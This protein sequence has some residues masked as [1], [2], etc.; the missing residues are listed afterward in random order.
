MALQ[1]IN[2]P[3]KTFAAGIDARSAENQIDPG[4]VRDLLN[5]DIVEKRPKKRTGY[6]GYAGNIP[7]RVT[8]MDYIDSTNLVCFTLDSAVSLDSDVNLDSVSS[9]PIIVYG[10]SSSFQPGDGPFTNAGD[11]RKYYD[12]FSIP[13]R[14]Q[15]LA[16]TNTLTIDATEHGIQD[17]SM[18]VGIVESTSLTNRSYQQVLTDRVA[19]D[20]STYDLSIDY[21]SY[22]NKN[23]YTYYADKSP[24]TGTTYTALITH[25]GAPLTQTFS[26]PETTHNLSNFNIIAQLQQDLTTE[27]IQVKPDELTIAPNG[28]VTVTIV[29]D[30]GLSQDYRLILSISPIT[31]V[32]TGNVN[33]NSTGTVVIPEAEKPWAFYGIYLEQTPGG[34]KE[35]VYPDTISYD[36]T[37]RD[38]TLTFTNLANVARNFIV[39]YDYG[40]LRSNQ[41]CV[42]DTDVTVDGSDIR[43]QLT[44]WGLDHEKIYSTEKAAREGWVNHIDSYRRSGEERIVAGLGGNLFTARSYF[45]AAATYG[46]PEIHANVNTRTDVPLTI[47]PAFWE[48]GELPGRTRGYITGDDSGTNWVQVSA[49][50]YDTGNGWT[51]Y[52]LSIPNMQLLDSAGNPTLLSN[53]ISTSG[54]LNDYLTVEGMSYARHNGVFKIRQVQDSPNTIDVWVENELNTEDYDDLGVGGIAGIFTDQIT[55]L[56]TAPYIPGDTLVSDILQ[57]TEPLT[58]ASSQGSTTVLNSVFSRQEIAAGVVFTAQRSSDVIPFRS[59][60]PDAAATVTNLVQG[61][62]LSYQEI[63]RYLRVLY[64]NP[65]SSRTVNITSD[66]EVATVTLQS[67]DT[68]YLTLG[69]K[70]LLTQAADYSGAVTITAIPSLTTFQFETT[71]TDSVSGAILVGKTAQIDESL[72]WKDTQSDSTPFRVEDRWIPLE[73]PDDNFDLTPDTYVRHLDSFNYGV[74]PFLRSTMVVDNLYLTN[75]SDEVYKMDGTNIYRAGLIPWQPGLFVTQETTGATIVTNLRSISYSAIVAGE[76]KLTVTA[77]TQLSL[78]LGT[79]VRLSG[80]SQTYIITNHSDDGSN[81]YI[82]MDR[83]L[84][85]TVSATGTIAEIGT[86]R[87]YY[88]LNAVDANDNIIASA[89]TGFQDHVV[90]LTGNAAIRHKI[91]G[92]PAWDVY[93]YDRLEVQIFRTKLNTQAPFYRITTL[94]MNFNNTTGYVTFRDSFADVDLVDLD[95]V[96]TSLKGAELGT[97]WTGPLRSKYITSIGNR[98]VL[99]NVRDYPELSMQ[100]VSDATLANSTLDG[101]SLLFRRSNIDLLSST[102]NTNR[103]RYEWVNGFTGTPSGITTGVDSFT[104]QGIAEAVQEGD[105]IY[106]TYNTVATTGRD[107]AYSGWWQIASVS[108]AGPYDATINF[109]GTTAPSSVPNRYVLASTPSDVPVLLGTDGNLGMVNGDSFDTFDATRR[110]ALAINSSMR[111]VDITLQGQSSFT[112]WLVARSGNDTPPAGRLVVRQPRADISIMEVVPTFSG[113]SLFINNIRRAT[114][115]QVSASTRVYPSRILVSYENYPEIFDNPTTIID[116]GSDSAIDINSADGQEITGILP[117][118]GEAAFGAAQQSAILVVFKTNSIYLVDINQKLQGLNPVQRIE[119]EGL[120]CTFPYSI[121]V[122]KKGIIFAN[123]SGIYCLRR[124]QSIEYLGRFM[125]RNWTEK[126]QLEATELVQGHHYGVGRVYKLSVPVLSTRQTNGYNENSEVYVYNHTAEQQGIPGA[127]TRYDNH[128]ATGWANL[129][130]DA[131]FGSTKGRVFSVRRTGTVTDFRD[132]SRPIR[133]VLDTRANDFGDSSVRKVLG[134]TTIHYRSPVDS[135]GTS[136][137]YSLDLE[138]EYEATTPFIVDKPSGGTNLSDVVG[139]D[140][141]TIKHNIR[142]RR[143]VYLQ[144]RIENESIDESIEIAGIDY[145]IAGLTDAGIQEAASTENT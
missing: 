55:W 87:Y 60:Y 125:E 50:E 98:L 24:V 29:N 76:G 58:V 49:V 82:L 28:D 118:F 127:W 34:I 106:L 16:G 57:T 89:I 1:Y 115:S 103:I 129:G 67:G 135:T 59:G 132:D 41:L 104:V 33:S 26:I 2:S 93:D 145:K 48:T 94:A 9:S 142:R 54:N 120:G 105:W 109:A 40:D 79:Q 111:Q 20:S 107:L 52:S 32:V 141:N 27:V 14:K 91:V 23:I 70:V 64:I 46:Y 15:F 75:G 144:L 8:R 19:I 39:F 12:R 95:E 83:A 66:G 6:Q 74:Q 51:K 102:D 121:A 86:Y 124:D 96:S 126:V 17:T 100:I 7:V 119:T 116:S 31:Q 72:T 53:I 44:I 143:F 42:V 36:D 73:A 139:R 25:S 112:P 37:T 47:A 133:F 84:D 99:G 134:N 110:M 30:T 69:A 63:A 43:P 81:F 90:E 131:F 38:I 138:Q 77:A 108:G 71:R 21:T 10:R 22:I 65:D 137:S 56:S 122:S 140:I 88:R 68:T 4:F 97:A 18:Y 128:P 130:T 3:E 62:M 78:P 117:F 92:L 61:D 35:L 85:S 113:Y 13:L 11:T 136:V 45:E 101:D 114:G 5:A 123:E 80:S